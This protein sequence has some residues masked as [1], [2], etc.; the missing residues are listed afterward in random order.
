MKYFFCNILRPKGLLGIHVF[1]SKQAKFLPTWH[2]S[3]TTDTFKFQ[4]TT[5]FLLWFLKVKDI[6]VIPFTG[7][8]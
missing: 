2:G 6:T 4:L 5:N 1:S 7:L 3:S 8:Y